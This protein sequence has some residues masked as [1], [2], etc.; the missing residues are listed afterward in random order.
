MT[1]RPD[2]A[3]KLLNDLRQRKERMAATQNSS[4]QSS[5][6][7]RVTRGSAG[8]T[9]RG[10]RQM[11]V[12][13]STGSMTG[14]TSR[15]STG[16]SRS[17]NTKET[18]SQLVLYEGG[19]SSRQVRDLSMAIAFAFENSGNLSSIG[20]S[21]SNPLV[22][23]FNRFGRRSPN[24]RKMETTSFY[25]HSSAAQFPTGSHIH[26]NEISKGVHKLNQ[27]LSACSNG[28]NLDRN[29][30]EIG[31]ELL[32]G[33]IDLEESLRMLV[34]LQ[35]ASEYTN[36]SQRKGRIK[37]L[38]EDEDDEDDN[39]KRVEQWKL[40]RPRFSFDKTSGNPRAVQGATRRQQLALPY[41]HETSE[42]P[43]ISN[44][45]L[46]PHRRSNS[47]VQDFSLSPHNN[48]SSS[49]S[50]QEKGRISNV[51]AKLMGLEEI[52][53][54]EGL[55]GG[56]NDSK[57]KGLKQGKVSSESAKQKKPLTRES[58]NGSD[59][60]TNTKLNSTNNSLPR[61]ESKQQIK[62]EK[63]Q[64]T[65]DGG[66]KIVNSERNQPQ[67]DLKMQAVGMEAAPE[68]KPANIVMKKQQNHMNHVNG[69]TSFKDSTRKQ[70]HGE[71]KQSKA[72][73]GEGK[74]LV[75]NTELQKRAQ[76][77]IMLKAEDK[78]SNRIE[79]EFRANSL[80]KRNANN[81]VAQNQ[82]NVQDQHAVLQE[83]VPKRP[84]R[85]VVDHK[86]QQ[87]QKQAKIHEAQQ[88]E[89]INAPKIKR[90]T[91][92]NLQKK[93]SR[94]KSTPGD[95]RSIKLIEKVP[96]R[97]PVNRRH[98]DAALII[99][100]LQKTAVYQQSPRLERQSHDSCKTERELQIDIAKGSSN[101]LL[102]EAKPIEISATQKRTGTGKVQRRE[103]PE[104]IEVLFTR[105][106]ATGN[107]LTRST[108]R[109]DNM[110]KGLKQQMQNKN[111][112]SRKMEEPS[113]CKVKEGKEGISASNASEMV[114]EPV[115]L[116]VKLETKDDKTIILNSTL[117]DEFQ[118]QNMQ[119]KL[120]LN[121]K[122][123]SIVS[124]SIDVSND[125][126]ME[127]QLAALKDEEEFNKG[128]QSLDTRK[129]STELE[130]LQHGYM[131]FP[132]LN[133]QEQLTEP[134]KNLKETVIK[135]QMFLSTA[136]A[137]FKLNIP[138]SFLHAG[139]HENEVSGKKL[140][141]DSAN[142]VMKRKARRHEFTYNPY[143]KTTISNIKLRS[144]DDLVRQLCK[145]LE[146]L[147]S[148]GMNGSDECDVA[149]GLHKML[150]KDIYNEDP[151]VNCMWDF[152]WSRMMSIFP[153]MEAVVKDVERHMLNGLLD[154]ITNDLLVI[155]VS[156]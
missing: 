34:N 84:D 140:V 50:T 85:S 28:L 119:N 92:M 39:E 43:I 127:E 97:D 68:L 24:S 113:N 14:N 124:N 142:E 138:V 49:K 20:G 62:P 60:S 23:F 135:S 149:A 13:D 151:D 116:E 86:P 55:I 88:V 53:L 3:Q 134:E 155:T 65:L 118:N 7:S 117:A 76:S 26:V 133:K 11:N 103:I 110:L 93:L 42:Q 17:V 115:T 58:R 106:N 18:A 125:L 8:Q 126:Q 153:E 87:L 82:Q 71:D 35:D 19:Q 112:G 83:Q 4:R 136:E 120:D 37:L 80:E 70:T 21:S 143:M 31:R 32:K 9:S 57:G 61:R 44:S 139:D 99:D 144:L 73:E 30:I 111:R 109:P 150:N 64:E 154:E 63:S 100:N 36:G 56:K 69:L 81:Y 52:P 10:T 90:T 2:F 72:V 98:Q 156:A 38:E 130:L 47:Y 1:T 22:N 114:T 129:E 29:S 152:E 6:A 54:K 101:P 25:N 12:L 51:I 41:K 95:G 96:L 79:Q 148:Y 94:D 122:G 147:K 128:V 45:Q 146:L 102:A 131:Q 137:L 132:A 121:N 91:A 59:L 77:S 104:K 105:R 75:L 74:M 27:I 108:K 145:N 40:D 66:S 78:T 89:H 5:Q 46:V 67:K 48:L 16:G 141:L 33:A 15:R 107:R 123:D